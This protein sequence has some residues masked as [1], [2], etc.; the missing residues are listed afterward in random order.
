MSLRICTRAA[1]RPSER[2]IPASAMAGSRG[3]TAEVSFMLTWFRPP[4]HPAGAQSG[5]YG[6]ARRAV[7]MAA[8]LVLAALAMFAAPERAKAEPPVKIVA[9]GD[10][11]TA[12]FGLPARSEERRV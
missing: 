12:G 3:A 9:L 8:A 2:L 1:P 5:S 6:A 10:S 11:L 7:Q 4:E